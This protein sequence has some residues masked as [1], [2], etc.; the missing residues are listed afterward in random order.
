MTIEGQM[1]EQAEDQ[2]KNCTVTTD[3]Y[4]DSKEVT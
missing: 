3:N 1:E 2:N 4:E